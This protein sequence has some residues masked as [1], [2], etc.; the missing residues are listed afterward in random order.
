MQS[1]LS[2][3]WFCSRF[4]VANDLDDLPLDFF[5]SD[6]SVKTGIL[7]IAQVFRWFGFIVLVS[8]LAMDVAGSYN[9][10]GLVGGS[11]GTATTIGVIVFAVCGAIAWVLEGFAKD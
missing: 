11:G 7:R 1:A 9:L 3:Q 4:R 5:M 6:M 2:E 10:F 8:L